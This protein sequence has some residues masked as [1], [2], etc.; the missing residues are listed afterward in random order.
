M[1]LTFQYINEILKS[2]T[3]Q[4]KATEQY[5]VVIKFEFKCHHSNES[6]LVLV[7]YTAVCFT[8]FLKVK[9]ENLTGFCMSHF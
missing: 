2:V 9:F 6:T 8:I 4:M 7:Y 1:I 5:R 3:I